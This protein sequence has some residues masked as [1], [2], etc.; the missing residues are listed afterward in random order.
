MIN[1]NTDHGLVHIASWDDVVGI[2]GYVP[3]LDAEKH[4]LKE[5]IGNYS[6]QD[7][8]KCGLSNCH[9]PH[10]NGFVVVTESGHVTNIG[11]DCGQKYFGVEFTQQRR[12]FQDTVTERDNRERLESFRF[13]MDDV[14]QRIHDF[15]HREKG[16]IWAYKK[17]SALMAP[18]SGL[19]DFIRTQLIKMAKT[20]DPEIVVSYEMSDKEID[21]LEAIEGRKLQRPQFNTRKVGDVEGLP[22]LYPENDIRQLLVEK[23]K[24]PFEEFKDLDIYQMQRKDLKFW[25]KWVSGLE[26]AFDQLEDSLAEHGR[27]LTKWN[28]EQLGAFV[29]NEAEEKRLT[30]AVKAI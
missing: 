25:A 28:I 20:R 2:P 15:D 17:I 18:G 5:V 9:T 30:A 19:P 29:R 4:K 7:Q 1:L 11:K 6:L 22:A 26:A 21:D 24:R 10:N 13:Q 27:L 12:A 8:V 16:A 3:D 23:I 14:E